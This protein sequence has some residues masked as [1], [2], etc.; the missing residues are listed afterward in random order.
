MEITVER[1]KEIIGEI[2]VYERD[3]KK[4]ENLD[5]LRNCYSIIDP[6]SEDAKGEYEWTERTLTREVIKQ[7]FE[8]LKKKITT[9]QDLVKYVNEMENFFGNARRQQ[10]LKEA[11]EN[12]P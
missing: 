10:K 3:L 4:K 5:C 7:S 1:V 2:S 12:A 9:K 8:W 6:L 11:G